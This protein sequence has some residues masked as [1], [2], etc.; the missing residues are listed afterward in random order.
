MRGR[1]TTD[2]DEE[3]MT[4]RAKAGEVDRRLDALEY[5]LRVIEYRLGIDR[6]T[7]SRDS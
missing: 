1:V 5:R 4:A 3:L 7:D 6:D 2:P